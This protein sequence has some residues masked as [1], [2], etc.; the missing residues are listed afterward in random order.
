MSPNLLMNNQIWPPIEIFRLFIHWIF[1]CFEVSPAW[2]KILA[3]PLGGEG[4]GGWIL[5]HP[6]CSHW[7]II[8][9]S[10][11]LNNHFL[12]YPLWTQIEG[13]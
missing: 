13:I 10:K 3:L 11:Y 2:V 5:S 1:P 4:G 9:T 6:S 7:R 12:Y 8:S